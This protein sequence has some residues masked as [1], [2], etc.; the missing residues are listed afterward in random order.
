MLAPL[1]VAEV[2]G[3]EHCAA[4]PRPGHAHV[5]EFA[6]LLGV[7]VAVREENTGQRLARLGGQVEI[8]GNP[9]SLREGYSKF[10]IR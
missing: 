1:A 3:D 2:I 9:E 7:V 8:G 10:S 4:G 6:L 5:L